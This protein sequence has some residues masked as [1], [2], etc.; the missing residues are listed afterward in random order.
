VGR[1]V[2]GDETTWLCPPFG[3]IGGASEEERSLR[4]DSTGERFPV[5]G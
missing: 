3:S 5:L 2:V 1:I 4:C